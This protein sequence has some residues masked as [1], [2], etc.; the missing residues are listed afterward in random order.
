[1]TPES[2][3]Q[4]VIHRLSGLAQIPVEEAENYSH[5]CISAASEFIPRLKGVP[6]QV[7][8]EKL[9]NLFAASAYHR[10]LCLTSAREQQSQM[11]LSDVSVKN[12]TKT[13]CEAALNLKNLLLEDCA[14]ILTV[15]G[16]VLYSV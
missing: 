6:D 7:Q 13:S 12:D 8:R 10:Y 5:L 9:L 15:K 2:V 3:K 1:M 11:S 14:D 16:G 4:T